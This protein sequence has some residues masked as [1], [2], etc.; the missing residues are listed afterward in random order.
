MILVFMILT[1]LSLLFVI[2]TA[3]RAIAASNDLIRKDE[4][5]SLVVSHSKEEDATGLSPYHNDLYDTLLNEFGSAVFAKSIL[6]NLENILS[7]PSTSSFKVFFNFQ[8]RSFSNPEI[9]L[10]SIIKLSRTDKLK[11]FAQSREDVKS[12]Y[13][14]KSLAFIELKMIHDKNFEEDDTE[15][16]SDIYYYDNKNGGIR[17]GKY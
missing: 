13:I 14:Y 6:S 16:Y 11:T 4:S 12:E 3:V 7:D 15:V 17:Y 5:T 9:K 1:V 8:G 10:D 2:A